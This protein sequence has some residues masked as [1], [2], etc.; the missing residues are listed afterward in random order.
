MELPYV[1][2]AVFLITTA[3]S[4]TDWEKNEVDFIVVGAGAAGAAVAARLSEDSKYE[5][6]LVEAG[7]EPSYFSQI[8]YYSVG[9]FKGEVDWNLMTEKQDSAF[10]SY[11]E[12]RASWPRGKALGGSTI[13]N[14]MVYTRGSRHDYDYWASVAGD[15]WSYDSLLP[16]FRKLEDYQAPILNEDDEPYHSQ[17]GPVTASVPPY[18]T[19]LADAFLEAGKELGYGLVDFNAKN[20]T[21]FANTVFNI[22]NG[23]RWSTNDAYVKPARKR[24][25]FHVITDAFVTKVKFDDTKHAIGI[26]FR[27]YG[28]EWYLKARKEVI[29]SAGAVNTPQILMLS[30]I[31]P[32]ETLDKFKIPVVADLPGV[33][34]NLQDHLTASVLTFA[35]D[36]N[37]GFKAAGETTPETLELWTNHRQGPLTVP[38]RSEGIAF[39]SST[40]TDPAKDHPDIELFM[41]QPPLL[42]SSFPAAVAAQFKPECGKDMLVL[43]PLLLRPKSTGYITL[44][45]ADPLVPALYQPNYL[46]HPEDVKVLTEG[47]KISLKLAETKA[48]KAYGVTWNPRKLIGCEKFDYSSDAYWECVIRHYTSNIHHQSGTCKMGHRKDNMA[49][50]DPQLKVHEVSNLR[51]VDV[52]ICPRVVS[53]HTMIPAIMIG[54]K[55]ADMIKQET[56]KQNGK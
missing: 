26:N 3:A 42:P 50:V 53:A 10:L 29:L 6:A 1:V 43:M 49:V 20:M 14:A 45:S 8:P 24:S 21:G 28:T 15:D 33:G 54:E 46:S 7:G 17:N 34:Q 40:Y 12:Q 22:R 31:G 30:G 35:L 4:Q 41:T 38:F 47:I 23:T 32:K 25:N 27:K 11:N 18:R 16:Y 56:E 2:V 39:V 51:V 55:A 9:P 36:R 52:S 5:V 19:P 48:F 37:V 13:I 44:K